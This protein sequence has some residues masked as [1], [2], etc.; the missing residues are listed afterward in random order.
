MVNICQLSRPWVT[1]S[2]REDATFPAQRRCFRIA[3][4]A[5]AAAAAAGRWDR[6]CDRGAPALGQGAFIRGRSPVTNAGGHEVVHY[7]VRLCVLARV[8][9]YVPSRLLNKHR[10][11]DRLPEPRYNRRIYHYVFDAMIAYG[12]LLL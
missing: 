11:N 5:A 2:S 3:R 8:R 4:A 9:V 7:C 6:G 12:N 1:R 10:E